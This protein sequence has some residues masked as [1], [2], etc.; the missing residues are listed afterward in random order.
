MS[1]VFSIVVRI[2]VALVI[3]VRRRSAMSPT[4]LWRPLGSGATTI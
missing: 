3:T 4:H 1:S 2:I